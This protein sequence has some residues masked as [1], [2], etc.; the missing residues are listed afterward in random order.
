MPMDWVFLVHIDHAV[1]HAWYWQKSLSF[2][3]G[4]EIIGNVW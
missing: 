1:L 4:T 3:L 2:V